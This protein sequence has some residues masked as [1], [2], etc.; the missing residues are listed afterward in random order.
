MTSMSKDDAA[1][2]LKRVL[3]LQAQG[4]TWRDVAHVMNFESAK[5][6][7]KAAKEAARVSQ[8]TLAERGIGFS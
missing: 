8:R 6:A 3:E 7:K 1:R 4:A 2:T 5:V